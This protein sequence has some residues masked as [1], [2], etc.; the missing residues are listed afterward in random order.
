METATLKSQL[1][2]VRRRLIWISAT[3]G[4]FWS[5]LAVLGILLFAVWLDLLWELSPQARVAWVVL[6]TLG[7]LI[8]FA[9]FGGSMWRRSGDA[10]VVRRLDH[11]ASCGGAILSGWE[12]SRQLCAVPDSRAETLTN[13]LAGLA[14]GKANQLAEK[15]KPSEAVSS[16]PLRVSSSVLGGM[17]LLV[18]VLGV[19]LP[20]LAETEWRRFVQPFHDVP[21]FSTTTFQVEPGDAEVIYG[22]GLNVR[23]TIVGDA[24]EQVELVLESGGTSEVVPM[25]LEPGGGW[26]VC[27]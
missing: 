23:A 3:A 13:G 11:A 22:E 9:V 2:G 5:L 24:V 6:A 8:L 26:R 27:G 21:P 7:G 19:C 18:G 16:Q 14:V 10:L 4:F 12:L 17:F 25:F 1:A 15:V 20:T